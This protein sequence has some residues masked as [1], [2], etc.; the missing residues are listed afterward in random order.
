MKV[1]S[2]LHINRILQIMIPIL[3]LFIPTRPVQTIWIF[4]RNPYDCCV[5]RLKTDPYF[6]LP[7]QLPCVSDNADTATGTIDDTKI[8]I[9]YPDSFPKAKIIQDIMYL[10]SLDYVYSF[11]YSYWLL[12]LWYSFSKFLSFCQC[13]YRIWLAFILSCITFYFYS[14]IAL[15]IEEWKETYVILLWFLDFENVGHNDIY[16]MRLQWQVN[17]SRGWNLSWM[18]NIAHWFCFMSLKLFV[19]VMS[20]DKLKWNKIKTSKQIWIFKSKLTTQIFLLSFNSTMNKLAYWHK[21]AQ[22][23]SKKQSIPCF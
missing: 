1:S 2:W 3:L 9:I 11:K 23:S 8:I 22:Q 20:T 19:H 10:G 18:L 17:F 14:C 4:N 21:R 5:V 6:Q 16:W 7:P 12:I 13:C 15:N